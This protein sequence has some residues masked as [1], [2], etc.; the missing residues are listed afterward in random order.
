MVKFS[1]GLSPDK[2]IE[3]LKSKGFKLSFDYNELKAEAH[4]KAFTVAKVTRLDLLND[5]YKELIK[6]M[7]GGLPFNEFQQNIQ[8]TLAK[9]GWWGTQEI[10]NPVT[11]EIKT[12]KIGA[13]RLKNIYDT[14]MRMAYNVAREQQMDELP[15]SVYRRYVSALLETTR[16]S[17]AARHGI[18]KHK[19]DPWWRINSPLNGWGC[20]CKKVAYSL[21]EIIRKGWKVT[22]ENLANIAEEDF[23]YDTRAGSR[24]AQLSKLNLDT[25]LSSL[26]TVTSIK[27][28]DYADLTEEQLKEK[29]YNTLGISSGDTF[30]DAVQDP[31]V[32]DDALF[33]A[34]TGHTKIKKQDRWMYI[35]E[36][37]NAIKNP[38]EIYLA[39]N[40]DKQILE[41][42]M[43]RYYKGDGGG[44]RAVQVV[45]EY[46]E[47]KTQGITGYFIKDT[48]QV[49]KRRYEKLIY[50]K[51]QE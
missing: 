31:M 50:Q 17:H 16:T 35:D 48:K 29:F 7:E 12:I 27:K 23:A 32:I 13:H 36:I 28:T 5:I 18:I 8:P 34:G 40:E 14:N 4:H 38:D 33:T 6:A 21:K 41:K 11:G 44:K 49:E 10:V 26:P 51:G 3:Y 25:S 24:L 30:I 22:E 42:K 39:F 45:F 37:A 2:A 46:L 47:D 9:K 19:D 43:F 20:K 15:L 1:F